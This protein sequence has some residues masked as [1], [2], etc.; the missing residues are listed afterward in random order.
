MTIWKLR[1]QDHFNI[2]ILNVHV[3]N[4]KCTTGLYNWASISYANLF[5]EL[6]VSI[7]K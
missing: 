5:L 2:N 3:S 1:V 6:N 7:K 4:L